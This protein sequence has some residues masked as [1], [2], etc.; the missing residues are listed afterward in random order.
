MRLEQARSNMVEQQIRPWDVLDQTVLSLLAN[1][2]RDEYVPAPYQGL[3]YADTAIPIGHGEVM[4]PPRVEARLLQALG[5][6]S[7]DHILEVGTG[8]GY[9]TSLLAQLG[10]HV[11]SVDLNADLT[12]HAE[13]ALKDHGITN[14]SLET[15]D[16]ARGWPDRA[17]YDVIAMTG[18]VPYVHQALREQLKVGGRMFVIVGAAPAMDTILI[19]RSSATQWT[20]ESL[21]E[22]VV[23]KLH[24]IEKVQAFEL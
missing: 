2:P 9:L 13:A 6:V 14:V 17:P 8:T 11:V 16:A 19:R 23:P 5:I 3:A 24:H 4:M 1:S 10:R 18:S 15:G 22:T 12:Q 20:S 21:F 7:N